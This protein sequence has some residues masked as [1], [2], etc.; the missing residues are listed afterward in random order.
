MTSGVSRPLTSPTAP[1]TIDESTST[2]NP[3]AAQLP[4]GYTLSS[5][6]SKQPD[7]EESSSPHARKTID[8]LR[9]DLDIARQ[10]KNGDTNKNILKVYRQTVDLLASN[11]EKYDIDKLARSYDE[12]SCRLRAEIKRREEQ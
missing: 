12:I 5:N 6:Q 8:Q 4:E 1:S 10:S 2:R 9:K 11:W 3:F 7:N